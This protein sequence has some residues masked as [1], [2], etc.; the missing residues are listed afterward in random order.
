VRELVNR[1]LRTTRENLEE[2][3]R[4]VL[5]LRAAPLEGRTL[6]EAIQALCASA[7]ERDGVDVRCQLEGGAERLPSR[8]ELALYRVAKEA[9]TNGRKHAA[10]RNV[11][12]RL[13]SEAQRITL[14][15]ED[16]G[17]GFEARTC[18]GTTFGF[19]GM[20]ERLR[21]LSGTLRVESA[22]GVGT[23]ILASIPLA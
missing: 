2:A 20:C 7:S 13:A 14:C 19:Q 11:S 3:R 17:C 12:V 9:L 15:V 22:P 23:R 6:A 10:A 8:I 4:S 5:D 21:L 18:P 1:A 16:D